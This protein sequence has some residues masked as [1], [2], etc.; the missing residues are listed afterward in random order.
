MRTNLVT[1]LIDGIFAT[2]LMTIFLYLA[3][4]V[5]KK[6]LQVVHILGTMLTNETRQ[7]GD[8][9]RKWS[10]LFA[11]IVAHYLVGFV[12]AFIYLLLCERS[13][14]NYTVASSLV[15]GFFIGL[16]AIGVWWVFIKLHPNPPFINTSYYL[17]FIFLSHLIF[18][19]GI[20]WSR[21]I[22]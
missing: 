15:F 10:A 2:S 9:S 20:I 11:G 16:L 14:L 18:G 6:R 4:F 8:V 12:F 3:S 19:M 17:S 1:A 13:I 21:N 7:H 5:L 22:I